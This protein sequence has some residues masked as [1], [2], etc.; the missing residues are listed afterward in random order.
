MPISLAFF[1]SAGYSH[2]LPATLYGNII[3]DFETNE[4]HRF[5]YFNQLIIASKLNDWLSLELLPGYMHRNYI[6]ERYNSNNNAPDENGF[7]H[8]VL[9]AVLNSPNA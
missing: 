4:L 2:A 6:Q 3:K 5:N 1:S 9:E 7:L 8:L